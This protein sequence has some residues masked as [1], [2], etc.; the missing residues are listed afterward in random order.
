[1][2]RSV[3]TAFAILGLAVIL[4]ACGE[5]A[6][7]T[8]T[9]SAGS[10]PH[11]QAPPDSLTAIG[12]A[13]TVLGWPAT[14]AV[15]VTGYTTDAQGIHIEMTRSCGSGGDCSGPSGSVLI[16][17]DGQARRVLHYRQDGRATRRDT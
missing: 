7:G 4:S 14:A 5:R 1:M 8:R 11:E 17:P 16:G 13:R 6:P 9:A 10:A 15:R 12:R 3:M 2:Q